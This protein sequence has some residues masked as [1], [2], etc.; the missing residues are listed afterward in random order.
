L[1]KG[2]VHFQL[3]EKKR[4]HPDGNTFAYPCNTLVCGHGFSRRKRQG[5]TH[6]ETFKLADQK[7]VM[8]LLRFGHQDTKT[9]RNA[10]GSTRAKT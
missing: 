3:P 6:S 1:E 10:G 2:V 7:R 8:V 9:K 5:A 4:D